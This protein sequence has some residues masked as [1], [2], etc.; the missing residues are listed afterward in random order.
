MAYTLPQDVDNRPVTIVGA[1]TLGRRIA[2]MYVAGG[3]D[4]R[5]VDPVDDQRAAALDFVVTNA[6]DIRQRLGLE[7]D[8]IGTLEARSELTD[9]VAGAWMVIE[10]VPERLDLK[11]EV[12]GQLD[13]L[14]DPDAILGSN[15]SSL[16]SSSLID[17]VDHPER[18]L[19]T[20]Y[21]IPPDLNAV[22]LMSDGRTD[23]GIIDALMSRLPRYGFVPF[24][25]R[26]ESDGLILNRVW[27]AI[28]RECLMVVEEGVA[29]PEDVDEMCRL[30][31]ASGLAPF[32][33]M[34]RVGLD[35]VLDIEEHYAAVRPGLP[36]GPRRLLRGYVE[37]G[38]LGV[39]TGRGFYETG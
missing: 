30:F 28:K 1:G 19:N 29:S 8:R 15:S 17:K 6:D 13:R 31:T 33:L 32:R 34:D 5:I 35:V 37:R 36:E 22:E 7:T 10:A 2:A 12:F 25:V 11:R 38:W 21:Q 26:T 39:K 23:P 20:H 4:V 3:S 27:A 24:R 16:P 18:V 9:A 14:A